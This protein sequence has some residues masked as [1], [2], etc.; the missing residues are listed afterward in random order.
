MVSFG[1]GF[2]PKNGSRKRKVAER[3]AK[4]DRRRDG[5]DGKMG[6]IGEKKDYDADVRPMSTNVYNS[7]GDIP[8]MLH[9][10]VHHLGIPSQDGA[11]HA[12]HAA[13]FLHGGIHIGK[14]EELQ[15]A[16][17]IQRLGVLVHQ[18]RTTSQVEACAVATLVIQ[19]V[20]HLNLSQI[21]GRSVGTCPDHFLIIYVPHGL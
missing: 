13:I 12:R 3:E 2:L 6:N 19:K 16:L 7:P 14:V 20:L 11:Q 18:L 8:T 1:L 15:E 21:C 10:R 9:Q 17:Q 5:R 4:A